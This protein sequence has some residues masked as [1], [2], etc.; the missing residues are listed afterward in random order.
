M[1]RF[2]PVEIMSVEILSVSRFCLCRD[3]VPVE[4]MSRGVFRIFFR[5]VRARSARKNFFAPRCETALHPPF[6]HP[7]PFSHFSLFEPTSKKNFAPSITYTNPPFCIPP[8]LDQLQFC[9]YTGVRDRTR[10]FRGSGR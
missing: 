5:W 8:F 1:S 10:K 3:S 6:S 2:C 4:I 7:P 9:I